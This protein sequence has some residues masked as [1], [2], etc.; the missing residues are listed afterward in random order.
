MPHVRN[1]GRLSLLTGHGGK[2]TILPLDRPA[3]GIA[4]SRLNCYAGVGEDASREPRHMDGKQNTTRIDPDRVQRI[5]EEARNRPG[6]R[7][8][9]EV[10]ERTRPVEQAVRVYANMMRPR[11]IVS[12]S[13]CSLPKSVS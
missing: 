13:N 3:A 7:A 4:A 6:V 5:L 1:A 10:Y 8:L 2:Y 9:M 12:V 11:A